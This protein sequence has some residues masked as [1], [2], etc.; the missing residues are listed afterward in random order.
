M[1]VCV[2]SI[3]DNA[4]SVSVSAAV[5]P[6][7]T[8]LLPKQPLIRCDW[9]HL[10][11]LTL[12]DP[13]YHQPAGI[14]CILGAEIYPAILRAGVRIGSAEAPVAQETIFG[15]ILT[16]PSRT[17]FEVR[18]TA[19]HASLELSEQLRRFW[20][21]EEIPT[22]SSLSPEEEKCENHFLQTHSRNSEGRY[23]VFLPF[24]ST[25]A[26]QNSRAITLTFLSSL[27]RR[28]LRSSTLKDAYSA[29]MAAYE[30]LGHM[31]KTST[32]EQHLPMACYLPHHAVLK[33]GRQSSV[34]ALTSSRASRRRAV[35]S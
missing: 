7:L 11:G 4:S 19:C 27:E 6:K 12:A 14:D 5:L 8:S 28:L 21:I 33:Q 31:R 18:L 22:A 2:S 13:N 24:S 35:R 16:G 29:F 15:W 10:D 23:V 26:L 1:Q 20:E 17:D 3:G 25:P 32:S 30:D 34:P 9:P